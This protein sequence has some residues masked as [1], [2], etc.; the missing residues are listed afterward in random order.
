MR[1][2][3]VRKVQLSIGYE[4]LSKKETFFFFLR[5]KG[6]C[7]KS[8]LAKKRSVRRRP[9]VTNDDTDDNDDA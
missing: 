8:H 9:W 4:R 7:S 5:L 2:V 6:E 1:N 3:N